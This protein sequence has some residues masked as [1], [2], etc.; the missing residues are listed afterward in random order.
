M[1]KARS[2]RSCYSSGASGGSLHGGAIFE[3]E[4]ARWLREEKGPEN[5]LHETKGPENRKVKSNCA[6]L[7]AA[8]SVFDVFVRHGLEAQ[9]E[10]VFGLRA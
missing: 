1:D 9:W 5:L 7:C 10:L 2:G 3:V 6:P 8:P 4:K